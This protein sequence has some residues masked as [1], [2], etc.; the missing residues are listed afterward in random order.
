MMIG[1]VSLEVHE[2]PDAIYLHSMEGSGN[3]ADMRM[4]VRAVK[5]LAKQRKV[6]LT[7]DMDNPKREKLMKNYER[8]GATALA[9]LLEVK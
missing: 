6:Y 1:S 9:V 3:V 7:V 5:R 4:V 8:L 2:T